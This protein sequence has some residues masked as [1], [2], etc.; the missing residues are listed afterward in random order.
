MASSSDSKGEE[1]PGGSAAEA[2]PSCERERENISLRIS[3]YEVNN[4]PIH[5][6]PPS[7]FAKLCSKRNPLADLPPPTSLRWTTTGRAATPGDGAERALC[8]KYY[9]FSRANAVQLLRDEGI[10]RPRAEAEDDDDVV[11][12]AEAWGSEDEEAEGWGNDERERY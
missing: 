5:S 7:T 2:S 3:K 9:R 10:L 8:V 11:E 6:H 4:L 1:Q 12:E